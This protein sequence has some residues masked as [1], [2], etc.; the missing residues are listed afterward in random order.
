MYNNLIKH[1]TFFAVLSITSS[2]FCIINSDVNLTP[3]TGTFNGDEP[4]SAGY[5]EVEKEG[6]APQAFCISVAGNVT[7]SIPYPYAIDA[8]SSG[9]SNDLCKKQANLQGVDP[10]IGNNMILKMSANGYQLCNPP[11]SFGCD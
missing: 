1:S 3:K 9:T 7:I 8:L 5:S 6:L 10:T 4:P 11:S 2:A